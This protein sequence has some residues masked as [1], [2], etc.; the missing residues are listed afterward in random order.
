MLPGARIPADGDVVAGM[1][2]IDE[3]M[4]T[5]ESL[6][7][8]KQPGH[9]VIGGT[10][11]AGGMIQVNLIFLFT[12]FTTLSAG[13]FHLPKSDKVCIRCTLTLI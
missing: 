12:N 9:P 3:S 1:T 4:L 5:G 7:V 6:P 11:N 10:M 2:H 13:I 8:P